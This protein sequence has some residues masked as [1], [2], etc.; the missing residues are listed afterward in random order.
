MDVE[1]IHFPI[2]RFS[3]FLHCL[4]KARDPIKH[5]ISKNESD[6]EGFSCT[7]KSESTIQYRTTWPSFSMLAG[8]DKV[9]RALTKN[10]RAFVK[11]VP[12]RVNSLLGCK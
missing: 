7:K 2:R 11:E 12:I 10:I 1:F 8:I 9:D 6:G 3:I 4:K 5:D